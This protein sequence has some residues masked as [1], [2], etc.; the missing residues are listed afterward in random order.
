MLRKLI[1]LFFFLIFPSGA[2]TAEISGD[3][4]EDTTFTLAESPY[5]IVADTFVKEGATLTVE[6]GVDII[7]SPEADLSVRGR[8]DILGTKDAGVNLQP[9]Q[10]GT[11]WGI[12]LNAEARISHAKF[13]NC[14][15]CIQ[16][17]SANINLDNVSM[18]NVLREAITLSNSTVHIAST[19]IK[20]VRFGDAVSFYENSVVNIDGLHVSGVGQGSAVGIYDSD[21]KI[22]RSSFENGA[23][24][25]IEAYANSI[26]SLHN[27]SIRNFSGY[28]IYNGTPNQIDATQN[29]WGRMEN[30]SLYGEVALDIRLQ[31]NPFSDGRPG[32]LFLPGFQASRLYKKTDPLLIPLEN[33]LWE[34]NRGDDVRK[35]FMNN[36]GVSIESGIYTKDI[37]DQINILGP[38]PNIYKS[39]LSFL[40][41]MVLTGEIFS[42]KTYPYDWRYDVFEVLKMNEGWLENI[43]TL[44]DHTGKVA[45]VAHSNGGLLAKAMLSVIQEKAQTDPTL[46]D[47][48]DKVIFVATPHFGTPAAIAGLLHGEGQSILGGAILSKKLAVEFGA[49]LLGGYGLLPSRSFFTEVAPV[50]EG[51]FSADTFLGL[52]EFLSA[53]STSHSSL[54]ENLLSKTDYIHNVVDNISKI[55]SSTKLYQIIG[56]GITTVSG[57]KYYQKDG[58]IESTFLL[59]CA[60]NSYIDHSPLFSEEGDGTVLKKSAAAYDV[61]TAVVDIAGYN[62][63]TLVN[64]SHADILEIP[65]TREMVR[66]F[67]KG[68]EDTENL[69]AYVSMA[70]VG[71]AVSKKKTTYKVSVHSPVSLDIYD[72]AGRHTGISKDIENTDEEILKIDTQIP[73]SSYWEIGE[74]KQVTLNSPGEYGIKLQGTGAGIFSL[75][76]EVYNNGEKEKTVQFTDVP[77]VHIMNA[78]LQIDANLNEQSNLSMDI[79]GDGVDDV[80]VKSGHQFDF[81]LYAHTLKEIVHSVC[82]IPEDEKKTMEGVIDKV[83]ARG[84]AATGKE[85]RK[86]I[87]VGGNSSHLD[88]YTPQQVREIISALKTMVTPVDNPPHS[89]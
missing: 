50:I 71:G 31:E 85:K 59:P 29:W 88:S 82:G 36:S 54:S 24:T 41:D 62:E 51:I 2:Y 55:A 76:I 65:S 47:I 44:A 26:L 28:D 38:G 7:F 15:T 43:R 80:A 39:F 4:E 48:I 10:A 34:P 61:P 12:F 23:S 45:L 32:V 13:K 3:T 89:I 56:D 81:D 69:P 74:G 18:E 66:S 30:P 78:H 22:E 25:A 42:W 8:L 40:G 20:N 68:D 16:G 58:C 75:D 84:K 60:A 9:K 72:S 57:V 83:A 19:T 5:M 73:N 87:L 53:S 1:L 64:R 27:S 67:I 52:R 77:T 70:A 17:D 49:T 14:F 6:P 63:D 11:R 86:Y 46:V 21:V 79:D 33:Q 37:I 35:L